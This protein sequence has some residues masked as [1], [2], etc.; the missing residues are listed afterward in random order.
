MR[1]NRHAHRKPRPALSPRVPA[2]RASNAATTPSG[3]AEAGNRDQLAGVASPTR[4]RNRY[5]RTN[6]NA[7]RRNGGGSTCLPVRAD[8]YAGEIPNARTT[9]ATPSRPATVRDLSPRSR[10]SAV[11]E[12]LRQ[13]VMH[14]HSAATC[15]GLPIEAPNGQ[16]PD[17]WDFNG[18]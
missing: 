12:G 7:N 9:A 13:K 6:T 16:W 11:A 1:S 3:Y 14:R 17:Q 15:Y 5:G 18:R 2:T 4:M 8:E 10:D